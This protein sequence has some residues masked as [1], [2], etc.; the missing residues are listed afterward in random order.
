MEQ[1]YKNYSIDF[2]TDAEEWV[3]TQ[4]GKEVMRSESM[5][6]LKQKLIF[7]P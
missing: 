2:D 1:Q 6:R 7:D 4:D 3:A 5:P